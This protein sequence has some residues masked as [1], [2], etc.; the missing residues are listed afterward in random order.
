MNYGSNARAMNTRHWKH[1]RR[2]SQTKSKFGEQYVTAWQDGIK[3]GICVYIYN[4]YMDSIH[5]RTLISIC[6]CICNLSNRDS[7]LPR[8]CAL[9]KPS[10]N[11]SN[12]LTTITSLFELRTMCAWSSMLI[13]VLRTWFGVQPWPSVTLPAQYASSLGGTVSTCQVYAQGSKN[14]MLVWSHQTWR[15][16]S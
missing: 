12:S 10:S 6:S 13:V 8:A 11:S 3:W 5:A 2:P 4:T 15:M 1:S 14:C 16:L 7:H 9:V